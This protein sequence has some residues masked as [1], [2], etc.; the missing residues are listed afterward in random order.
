M[1]GGDVSGDP[2]PG[3]EQLEAA[4]RDLVGELEEGACWL[5][6]DTVSF[7]RAVVDVLEAGAADGQADTELSSAEV[8]REIANALRAARDY[9]P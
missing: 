3:A 7:L 2:L 8:W 4:G 9:R 5:N 1:L 6:A